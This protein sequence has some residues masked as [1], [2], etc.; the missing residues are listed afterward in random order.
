VA[1]DRREFIKLTMGGAAAAFFGC[2][3]RASSISDRDSRPRYYVQILL[4]GGHD[5]VFT[6]DP[7]VRS[8][9]DEGV[10]VP[11]EDKIV[12]A[13]GL[14]IGPHFAPLARWAHRTSF[15]NGVQVG[16]A[17][18]ETG[19][20]QFFRLKTNIMSRMPGALDI[21]GAHRDGQPVGA[22]YLN[23]SNRV[24]HSPLYFGTADRFSFGPKNVLDEAAKARPEDLARLAQRLKKQA[25]ELRAIS[26]EHSEERATADHIEQVAAYFERVPEVPKLK[27]Q[28]HS[29]DYVSQVMGEA[30][31]RALW[32]IENDLAAGILIDA[33]LTGWDTHINNESRQA[34]MSTNLVRYL[35]RFLTELEARSNAHGKLA[36]R[37]FIVGGADLGRFP[38]LNDMQG[39]DHFPQTSYFFIGSHAGAGKAYGRTGKQLEGLAIS[40]KTGGDPSGPGRLPILDDVGTTLLTIAGLDP[41]RFGYNGERLAFLA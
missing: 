34:E 26:G 16:T 24:L 27:V 30:F 2:R 36:D 41:E 12:D 23:I 7:K 6:T 29:T 1:V 5:S 9:V 17:N 18:H 11:P 31:D 32:L 39:K 8:D 25:R 40:T 35:D 22:V 4:S 21:I 10:D 3:G 33:G 38:R 19:L 14:R 13:K 15:L 28:Q 20:K 37:T